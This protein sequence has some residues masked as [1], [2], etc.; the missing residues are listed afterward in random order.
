ML[1]MIED[2]AAPAERSTT[3][4]VRGR[5]GSWVAAGL[6]ALAAILP[7][8]GAGA[9]ERSAV[10]AD[11]ALA[12]EARRAM[13][14]AA[15]FFRHTLWQDGAYVWE[16]SPDGTL[17]RG[18]GG[19]A[20][21]GVAW[22]QPPG[23]P[24]VGAAFLL[25]HEI[26]G[27]EEWLAAAADVAHALVRTQLVSGGWYYSAV[28]AGPGRDEWCYRAD[29]HDWASCEALESGDK[30]NATMLDDNT[31]QSALRFLI[32]FD[33]VSDGAD[34]DVQEAIS[35]GL[36]R[37]VDMQYPNGA[38]PA[39][40]SRREPEVDP[41]PVS[42]ARMP[43]SWSRTWVKPETPPYYITNDNLI[44]D[45]G[46]LFLSA[47]HHSGRQ[48]YLA[49][50]V[51]AGEFLLAAQ[52]P[53]PQ[54]GWA[55][56][57]DSELE[58]VW[59]RAF[60]PPSVASRETASS[61]EYLIEL[62]GQTQDRRYLDAAE[63]AKEWLRSVRLDDGQWARFYELGT[64]TPL[65]VDNSEHLTYRTDDLLDHYN[66][67]SDFGIV[68]VLHRLERTLKG[69]LVPPPPYWEFAGQDLQPQELEAE[70]RRLVAEQ[71][72]KG[73]WVQDGRVS[74]WD[75]VKG[76]G[77]L[78]RYLDS[79][80]LAE[81]RRLDAVDAGEAVP[82]FPGA[83]GYGRAAQGG[84]GG[85]II[86]VDSLEDAGKGTLRAC[87]EAHGP[88]NCIFRVSGTIALRKSLMVRGEEG[89]F[90]SLLG[91]TAPG[92]GIELTIFPP[93]DTN[94]LTPLVLKDTH[95][96]IVRNIRVRPRL[97]QEVENVDAIQVGNS[98]K[99]Y[100]DHVSTA[101][102][103]DENFN[104]YGDGS[105]LTVANSI[106]AEG[107]RRHSKCALLT[108]NSHSPQNLSFWRNICIS[109][110]DRN[111]NI[112]HATGSCVDIVDNLFY[113]ARSEWV[114]VFSSNGGSSVSVIGNYFKAGPSTFDRTAAVTW[115][116]VESVARPAI[117][118]RN[119]SLW[120]PEKKKIELAREG[121]E[122]VLSQQAACPP[123]VPTF[124]DPALSY[125]RGLRYAGAHP[126]DSIDA[127]TR[128]RGGPR[129]KS[130]WRSAEEGRRRCQSDETDRTGL[131]RYR[132]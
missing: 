98:R 6:F 23:T 87:V 111:P 25:V 97:N 74:G 82:A 116:Q 71:D 13:V 31:T 81:E 36:G 2:P 50:A 53:R 100:I 66:L 115:Q 4:P 43:A 3:G 15:K 67:M 73:R 99:V 37:L 91:Q 95:D 92:T 89:A 9:E 112:N 118:I 32:W 55:Q 105:D 94:R 44:R 65:Y 113:N 84:R 124:G 10:S 103:T 47:F 70:V 68:S 33:E 5:R 57:Y 77:I 128:A 38:W 90:L 52:L 85:R 114:E 83:Q 30:R 107:L 40:I 88:R 24:A 29:G 76:I 129:R 86:H 125:A 121:T 63:K 46:R 18:E 28:P 48:E 132:W 80:A 122:G 7:G 117:F 106:F 8:A 78:A 62:Y 51:R 16:Y 17:R 126:R 21:D 34:A 14:D 22:I 131:R 109:N 101:W 35:Y 79:E 64:N 42:Q 41:K 45:T 75:F 26:T 19:K 127:E 59:G 58:P 119:N 54:Q 1:W 72:E 56:T 39:R 12:G 123:S 69:D 102:A 108:A 27:D 11:P 49:A 110:N 20:P 130:G 96:I 104:S 61:I 93:T 120:A 60:E